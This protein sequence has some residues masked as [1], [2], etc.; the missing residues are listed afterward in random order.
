MTYV[1][2]EPFLVDRYKVAVVS[3]QSVGT[4]VVG[5]H[6]IALQCSKTPA[7]VVVLDGQGRAVL[8]MSGAKVPVAQASAL[9]PAIDA[10]IRKG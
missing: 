6:G 4:H 1:L 2:G 3:R 10:L 5:R 8:D 7:F 9:C